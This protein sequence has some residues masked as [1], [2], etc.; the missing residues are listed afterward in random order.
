MKGIMR[1]V[2]NIGEDGYN[3][4]KKEKFL[5]IGECIHERLSQKEYIDKTPIEILEGKV[6]L[7]TSMISVVFEHAGTQ[8]IVKDLLPEERGLLVEVDKYNSSKRKIVI[9]EDEII[10]KIEVL[11]FLKSKLYMKI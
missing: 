10:E 9:T 8:T 11:K 1:L 7:L 6:E 3:Y 2:D 4:G 5:P